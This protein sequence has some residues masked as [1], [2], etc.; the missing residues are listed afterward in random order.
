[1]YY[2]GELF[3]DSSGR[4]KNW[5]DLKP[6]DDLTDNTIKYFFGSK[7]SISSQDQRLKSDLNFL[8]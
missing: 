4:L 7:L 2:I 3:N 1:M 8:Y 6:K 5:N